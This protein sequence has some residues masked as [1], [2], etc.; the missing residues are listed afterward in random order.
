MSDSNEHWQLWDG[1]KMDVG[2]CGNAENPERCKDAW[3]MFKSLHHVFKTPSS[4]EASV[5]LL[6]V[7]VLSAQHQA[8]CVLP[9]AV[10]SSVIM[11]EMS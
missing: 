3:T 2:V 4:W 5:L 9:R 8:L 10:Q 11:N 6:Q 7:F 1:E